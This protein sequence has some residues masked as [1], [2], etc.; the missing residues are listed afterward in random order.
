MNV[1]EIINKN[2]EIDGNYIGLYGPPGTGKTHAAATV[3]LSPSDAVVEID[4]DVDGNTHVTARNLDRETVNIFSITLTEGASEAEL[5]GHYIPTETGGEWIDGPATIGWKLSHNQRVRFIVNEVNR[6]SDEVLSFLYAIA[7]DPGSPGTMVTLPNKEREVIRPGKFFTVVAT[8]NGEPEDLPEALQDRFA[9][10]YVGQVNP[11]ALD[12][13]PPH[14]RGVAENAALADG[15]RRVSIRSWLKFAFL[16]DNGMSEQE[17]AFTSF[18]HDR[19][20]DVLDSILAAKAVSRPE[21]TY[22]GPV[23]N[24][25]LDRRFTSFEDIALSDSYYCGWCHEPDCGNTDAECT[26]MRFKDET[27]FED[28]CAAWGLPSNDSIPSVRQVWHASMLRRTRSKPMTED[29]VADY[30]R[31]AGI[32][33]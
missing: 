33:G 13:L 7:D 14:L 1:W 18:G 23:N 2:L 16:M 21:V 25:Y 6:A 17:A 28:F 22:N 24:S 30:A 29:N 31:A 32:G 10:I 12:T 4:T 19:Y 26:P 11:A 20:R 27:E 9:W 8:M 5:R 15:A 3:G